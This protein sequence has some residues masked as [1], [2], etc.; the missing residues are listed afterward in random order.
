MPRHFSTAPVE[1]DEGPAPPPSQ[2][3]L[4]TPGYDAAIKWDQPTSAYSLSEELG[5]EIEGPGQAEV[6]TT[7]IEQQLD[8]PE[9]IT[10]PPLRGGPS[11]TE[12]DRILQSLD[13]AFPVDDFVEIFLANVYDGFIVTWRESR[14]VWIQDTFLP[15]F[16]KKSRYLPRDVRASLFPTALSPEPAATNPERFCLASG[17]KTMPMASFPSERRSLIP[18]VLTAHFATPARAT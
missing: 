7:R 12:V 4:I 14:G 9:P 11:G 1:K 6:G 5:D 10:F 8:V 18:R 16:E 13:R 17:T 2:V 15:L 3:Q